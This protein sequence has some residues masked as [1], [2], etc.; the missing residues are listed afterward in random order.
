MFSLNTMLQYVINLMAQSQLS[1]TVYDH[2]ISR[3]GVINWAPKTYDLHNVYTRCVRL[4]CVFFI[5]LFHTYA[6]VVVGLLIR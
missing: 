3:N 6:K 4:H 2:L 1:H 5:Y